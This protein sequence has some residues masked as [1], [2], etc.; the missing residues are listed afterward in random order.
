M[1]VLLLA[2]I[3]AFSGGTVFGIFIGA[4][5]AI[6]DRVRPAELAERAEYARVLHLDDHRRHAT[7]AR[8][9]GH[10]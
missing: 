3:A 9:R 1:S 4:L 7:P 8:V 6:N 5:C 10:R 2:L